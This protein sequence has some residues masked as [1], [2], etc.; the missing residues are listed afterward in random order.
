MMGLIFN[1]LTDDQAN[2]M[3]SAAVGWTW[4]YRFAKAKWFAY[5]TMST[6]AGCCVTAL[7]DYAIFKFTDYSG[8]LGWILG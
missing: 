4:H 1:D 6:V 7:V 8:I 3:S 5:G 2:A